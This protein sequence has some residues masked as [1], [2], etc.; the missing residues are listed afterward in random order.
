MQEQVIISHRGASYEIGRG[1]GFYAIWWSSAS[2][3]QPIEWWQET[4][5]GWHAAWSRFTDVESRRTITQL[6]QHPLAPG[7]P[8]VQALPVTRGRRAFIACVLLGA[9]VAVGFAGIFPGY[10]GKTSLT[11]QAFELVPHLIYLTAQAAR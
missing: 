4:E 1:R 5:A 7:E 3:L 2:H 11:S 10:F 8:R 9:G 6:R